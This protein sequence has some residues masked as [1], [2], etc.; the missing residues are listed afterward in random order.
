MGGGG[1]R[2]GGGGQ[3]NLQLPDRN[4]VT[5]KK[6][7]QR[8]NMEKKKMSVISSLIRNRDK[9]F[10][11]QVTSAAKLDKTVDKFLDKTC[12]PTWIRTGG[13]LFSLI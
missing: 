4:T 5:T 13:L 10:G 11:I 9:I 7:W 1:G 2:R 6:R 8:M 3:Y 12:L